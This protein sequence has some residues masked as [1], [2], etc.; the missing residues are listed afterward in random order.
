[1]ARGATVL[2]LNQVGVSMGK[3]ADTITIPASAEAGDKLLDVYLAAFEDTPFFC[4]TSIDKCFKEV[5]RPMNRDWREVVPLDMKIIARYPWRDWEK[6][7]EHCRQ[8]KHEWAWRAFLRC[9][10][11]LNGKGATR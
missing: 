1:M 11:A 10:R 6:A 8:L 3:R 2:P 9:A 5:G 4:R 7:E